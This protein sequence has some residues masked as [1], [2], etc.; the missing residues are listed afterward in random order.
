MLV[1]QR[2]LQCLEATDVGKRYL[3]NNPSIGPRKKAALK[4][5]A[6]TRTRGNAKASGFLYRR[7]RTL[8]LDEKQ[9][10]VFQ[11][12][13]AHRK[14][15][16][17][18]NNLRKMLVDKTLEQN[19]VGKLFNMIDT[20]SSGGISLEEWKTGLQ[21]LAM[22]REMLAATPRTRSNLS[23]LI[24]LNEDVVGMTNLH[25]EIDTNGDGEVDLQELTSFIKKRNK[26]TNKVPSKPM[27]SDFVDSVA[28]MTLR[29][30]GWV[31]ERANAAAAKQRAL[32]PHEVWGM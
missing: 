8:A 14:H 4:L 20:D 6:G 3:A 26:V 12:Q 22:K 25:K 31:E 30:T 28:K 21:R 1:L 18:R 27:S 10:T 13:R 5:V 32:W 29:R 24:L 23:G 16:E 9:Q 19:G 2:Q 11:A 15:K 7:K 17:R